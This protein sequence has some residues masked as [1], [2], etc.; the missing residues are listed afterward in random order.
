MD[1]SWRYRRSAI[2]GLS[3]LARPGHGLRRR[4]FTVEV[5]SVRLPVGSPSP[6]EFLDV[7]PRN[8]TE[9]AKCDDHRPH[10]HIG[11]GSWTNMP[12]PRTSDHG[13]AVSGRADVMQHGIELIPQGDHLGEGKSRTPPP[14]E[15]RDH[16]RKP[17]S[18][19]VAR[20]HFR[21]ILAPKSHFRRDPPFSGNPTLVPDA[22]CLE[23]RTR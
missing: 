21:M 14:A 10:A 13:S 5:K 1:D 2:F 20:W 15:F 18:L 23:N 16:L 8:D 3:V 19:R 7:I 9:P 17:G 4:W 6:F 22:V 12:A 11:F